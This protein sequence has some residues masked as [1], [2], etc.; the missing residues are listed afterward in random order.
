[1]N[2]QMGYHLRQPRAGVPQRRAL[3]ALEECHQGL[4]PD[5]DRAFGAGKAGGGRQDDSRML[6]ARRQALPMQASEVGDIVSDERPVELKCRSQE[7]R[8]L[9]AFKLGVAMRGG[10]IMAS[11]A[12]LLGD[13]GVEH[14]VQQELHL[15]REACSRSH[16]ERRRS[17]SS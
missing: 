6:L 14:L 8:V 9:L 2:S 12:E 4:D 5:T 16:W 17:A 10:D 3:M 11:A 15:R 13:R 7:F 1:M